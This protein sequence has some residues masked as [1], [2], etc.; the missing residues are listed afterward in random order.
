[1]GKRERRKIKPT[2]ISLAYVSKSTG[3]IL[4][5]SIYVRGTANLTFY[6]Y[7]KSKA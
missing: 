6:V 5:M 1:M 2:S 4:S 3:T 7:A